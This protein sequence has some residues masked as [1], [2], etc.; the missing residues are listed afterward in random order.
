[1]VGGLQGQQRASCWAGDYSQEQSKNDVRD[2]IFID[3]AKN[4]TMGRKVALDQ[5]KASTKNWETKP[6]LEDKEI[7]FEKH[8]GRGSRDHAHV[9]GSEDQLAGL[10]S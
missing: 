7:T 2:P 1:M 9:H 6:N 5:D 10:P 4:K 8:L 3:L